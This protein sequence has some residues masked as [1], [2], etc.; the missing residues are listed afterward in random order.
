[1]CGQKSYIYLY[2]Y[3]YL[4]IYLYVPIYLCVRILYLKCLAKSCNSMWPVNVYVFIHLSVCMYLYLFIYLSFHLYLP[5]YLSI[6]G[7]R[8][9]L[10]CI[11]IMYI[12][13]C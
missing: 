6:I 1:M 9:A 13:M 11:G 4:S 10:V 5:I 8:H 7:P 12:E 3:M 2:M